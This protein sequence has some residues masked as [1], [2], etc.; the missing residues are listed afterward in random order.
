MLL[1]S[2]FFFKKTFC[3]AVFVGQ[4]AQHVPHSPWEQELWCVWSWSW[5]LHIKNQTE[6]GATIR[7]CPVLKCPGP[8]NSSSH[9]HPEPQ[10]TAGRFGRHLRSCQLF[11]P[12]LSRAAARSRSLWNHSRRGNGHHFNT[13]AS[14][15]RL[16]VKVSV[17]INRI[18]RREASKALQSG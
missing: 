17:H 7:A 14:G 4:V 3:F 12:V 2:Y 16:S 8:W 6:K 11:R 9:R 1:C 18:L 13:Q 10:L 5:A 15:R